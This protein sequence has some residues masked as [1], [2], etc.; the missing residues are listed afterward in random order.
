MAGTCSGLDS[1]VPQEV[2]DAIRNN[3]RNNPKWRGK[4]RQG[5]DQLD[6][7]DY[8]LFELLDRQHPSTCKRGNGDI[9]SCDYGHPVP[10]PN[11]PDPNKKIP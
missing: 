7:D 1:S 2:L 8:C 4:Y 9:V 3:I 10:P 11:P 5:K 6:H